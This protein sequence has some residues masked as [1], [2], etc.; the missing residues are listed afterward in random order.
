MQPNTYLFRGPIIIP[1]PYFSWHKCYSSLGHIDCE[2]LTLGD[3]VDIHYSASSSGSPRPS[4]FKSHIRLSYECSFFYTCC[5]YMIRVVSIYFTF[6]YSISV[7]LL[8]IRLISN[9]YIIANYLFISWI[10]LCSAIKISLGPIWVYNIKCLS[11][12]MWSPI[13]YS[14][15]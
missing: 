11:V 9:K 2:E 10:I 14:N 4:Y 6:I 5:L 3:I 7:E 1:P 13:P 8:S 15:K 12:M